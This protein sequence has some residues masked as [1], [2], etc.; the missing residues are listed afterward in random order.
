MLFVVFALTFQALIASDARAEESLKGTLN[1]SV[2]KANLPSGPASTKPGQAGKDWRQETEASCGMACRYHRANDNLTMQA[3]YLVTKIQKI[4]TAIQNRQESQARTALG[5]FC[6][7]DSEEVES[8]FAR[9]RDF[10]RIGLLEIRQSIGKN[11]DSIARLTTGRKADGTVDGTALTFGT[12]EE[13]TAY[14][15]DVP[16]LSELEQA[17]LRGNLKPSGSKYSRAEIQKWSQDLIINN[18]KTRYLQFTAKPVVG[19][20]YQTEKT[21]YS[22]YMENRDES[23]KSAGLDDRA[24]TQRDRSMKSIQEFAAEKDGAD[25]QAKVIAPSKNLKTEDAITYEA[26]TEAR[27]VVN[28]KI[29]GDVRRVD[30]E[31]KDRKLASESDPKGTPSPGPSGA[32]TS[33]A[34]FGNGV[35]RDVKVTTGQTAAR[36]PSGMKRYGDEEKVERPAE[37]KNSRYIKYDLGDLMTDI[38]STK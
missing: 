9:Y 33:A 25:P 37:M 17:Y 36:T 23:G 20:P 19:N 34:N 31:E 4:E 32:P 24:V 3:L 13:K 16:T 8:C 11:E 22:I 15:P 26:I 12:G 1:Q 27:S 10:Q 7:S 28:S 14:L 2:S 6:K 5:A 30:K 18:P 35:S 29:E 38:E 21:S